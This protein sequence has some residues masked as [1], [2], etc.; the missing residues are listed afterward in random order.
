MTSIGDYALL[1]DCHGAALVARDGT[2]A[3]WCP[4]RFDARSIFASLLDPEAG[5]WSIRPVGEYRAE[6]RYLPDTMVLETTWRTPEGAVR[7]V[8]A[9]ALGPGERG[10]DIGLASPHRLLRLVE[11]VEGSVHMRVEFAPR[12]EYGLVVPDLKAVDG[13]LQTLGGPDALF[14]AGDQAL[15]T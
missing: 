13:G 9:L 5:H 8:D 1:G 10:H 12:P 15:V 4:E 6:R 2:V 11:G 3:W 7:V 14:L